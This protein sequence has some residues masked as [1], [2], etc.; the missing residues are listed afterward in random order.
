MSNE[1]LLAQAQEKYPTKTKVKGM[2]TSKEYTVK[3]EPFIEGDS[4]SVYVEENAFSITLYYGETKEWA[5]IIHDW[6]PKE[7]EM[8]THPD[9]ICPI[10]MPSV[11]VKKGDVFRWNGR[12]YYN[13]LV[14]LPLELVQSWE[15][16]PTEDDMWME[17]WDKATVYNYTLEEFTNWAKSNYLISR[18]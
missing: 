1:Q 17:L 4:I 14:Y 18:K 9:K 5:E 16:V 11:G 8:V 2:T 13:E 15:N 6:Q 3:G 7:G 12:E 10:D